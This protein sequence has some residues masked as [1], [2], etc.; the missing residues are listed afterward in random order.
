M[1][2]GHGPSGRMRPYTAP[3]RHVARGF[4]GVFVFCLASVAA[5]C[6][7]NHNASAN[8]EDAA[9]G[10]DAASDDGGGQGSDA[11]DDAASD[12]D[13]ATADLDSGSDGSTDS[14]G[15]TS[16]AAT[17]TDAT[18]D[19]AS[20]DSATPPSLVQIQINPTG[21]SIAK[22]TTQQLTA[23]GIY[24]DD[25][26]S[27]LSAMVAWS[28]S[29]PTKAGV[30]ATGLAS[31]VDVGSVTINAQLGS[32]MGT[33]TL[34]VTAATLVAVDVTPAT[35]TIAPGTSVQLSATGTFSDATTQDLTATATWSS[36]AEGVATVAS[37]GLATGV[38][39]GDATISA[40]FGGL[41][42][43][44]HLTVSS[45]TLVSLAI[46][47]T[48]VTIAKGTT[49]AFTA[50]GTFSD[51][52]T[53]DLTS[54]VTWASADPDVASVSDEAASKGLAT[55][56]GVGQTTISATKG[57]VSATTTL[58]VTAATLGSVVVT[59]AN[60]SLPAGTS[61]QYT[62]TGMYSDGTSQDLTST[63]VWASS[64]P[65]VLALSNSGGSRGLANAATAGTVTVS[66][67]SDGVTGS[68]QATVTAAV[69]ASL[70]VSPALPTI[71][72]GTTQ[73]F[74][75]TG[76]FSDGSTRDLT[77][78]VTWASSSTTVA[79]ISNAAGSEG[80]AT[81]LTG[82]QTTVSATQGA[83]TGSATLTVSASTLTSIA[84][85]PANPTIAKGTTQAF[86]ATGTYSDS[87]TQDLTA[88]V[89]WKSSDSA[90]A[91]VSNAPGSEGI[92]SGVAAGR[93]LISATLGTT[94]ATTQLTVNPATLVSIEVTP[95]DLTSPRGITQQYTA[96]GTFSDGSKQDLTALV[97][98]NSSDT[99]V[100][101]IANGRNAR[102]QVS[103]S[104]AGQTT[105][106]ATR[107]SVTGST[108]L[109]VSA[110]TLVSIS[111]TPA[112]PSFAKGTTF[113]FTATGNYS[114][115][116]TQDLTTQVTWLSSN[117]SVA[118][119]SNVRGSEGL[120]SAVNAGTT[121]IRAAY[122]PGMSG[123]TTATVA[124]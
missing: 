45:A 71:S 43:S 103:T 81:G 49:T 58:S 36:S 120:A 44:A 93:T 24:S 5:G 84:I 85:T 123:N 68:T 46:S 121:T 101:T 94:L 119:I 75:A 14:D 62:A 47:P 104:T 22:G 13:G 3:A 115:S 90:V 20:A 67:T 76:T 106:S 114:D 91:T 107:N 108:T 23:T 42:G 122:A 64:D 70:T 117:Q 66:A 17:D 100:A 96:E 52:S 88:S 54:Q 2:W 97:N 53:Q 31:G 41:T 48:D 34:S 82:G 29:D 1:R 16:D 50:T 69:L 8:D 95:S 59:P 10:S 33:T 30:G 102:G 9:L 92:A 32:V 57:A 65:T 25:S 73:Q 98:W 78:A 74:T 40:S 21:A 83:V 113:Q 118:I 105:I 111:V 63:V 86:V 109:T 28:S 112:T 18:S 72:R 4:L 35:T 61:Q 12:D 11:G 99:R 116:S 79:A 19:S 51:N 37:G 110:A 77:D 87:T 60:Q 124:P 27:D 89:T 6:S 39:G 26:T 56:V 15:G 7:S 38:S 80:L 55:A